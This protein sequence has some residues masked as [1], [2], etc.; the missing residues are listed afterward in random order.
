M[1]TFYSPEFSVIGQL[2]DVEYINW[3]EKA[4]TK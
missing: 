4:Y 3:F 1:H 2:N